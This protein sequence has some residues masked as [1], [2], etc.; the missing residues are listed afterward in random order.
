MPT[1]TITKT[2]LLVCITLLAVIAG[3]AAGILARIDGSTV[4]ASVRAAAI[5]L[6]ASLTLF[7]A[8]LTAYTLL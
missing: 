3:L 5:G 2:L 8:I 1:S 7:L 6:G 4:A